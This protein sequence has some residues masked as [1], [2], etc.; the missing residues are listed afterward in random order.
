MKLLL[1]NKPKSHVVVVDLKGGLGNQL[2]QFAKGVNIGLEFKVKII[3]STNWFKT[4]NL[5]IPELSKFNIPLD[6]VVRPCVIE[7]MLDFT[8]DLPCNCEKF[9]TVNEK[10]FHFYNIDIPDNC[11]KLEGYWQSL[12]NFSTYQGAIGNFL[13]ESIFIQ[14]SKNPITVHCRLGD[15]FK[16][17][18][19]QEVHPV[20]STQYYRKALKIIIGLSN[21]S[22]IRLVSDDSNIAIDSILPQ[23][24]NYIDCSSKSLID[25]FSTLVNS[26]HIIIGNSTFS[27]WAA[28]LSNAQIVIAP[29]RWFTKDASRRMNTSDLYMEN[30]III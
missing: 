26:E 2:F 21:E 8:L 25:D 30:W 24:F 3:F 18:N 6:Q 14:N 7:N 1:A 10:F 27:W 9:L 29:S 4:Q 23:E 22:S 13:R 16:N 17:K 15:Y 28:F 20:M 11:V 12:E 19:V 5:R